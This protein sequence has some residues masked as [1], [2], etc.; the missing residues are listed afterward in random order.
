MG[1]AWKSASL[2]GQARLLLPC[3]VPLEE[4]LD[5]VP[6]PHSIRPAARAP[7]PQ[8]TGEGGHEDSGVLLPSPRH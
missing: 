3:P 1:K 8:I 2:L 6:G 5:T 4:Q 7:A